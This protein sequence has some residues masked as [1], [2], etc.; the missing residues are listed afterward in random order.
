MSILL[1][2]RIT[3]NLK[4]TNICKF[5]MFKPTI[6]AL[7]WYFKEIE[8]FLN[9]K[10]LPSDKFNFFKLKYTQHNKPFGKLFII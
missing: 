5:I 10:K 6:L 3:I 1:L 2:K 8:N 9:L 7:I 4:K